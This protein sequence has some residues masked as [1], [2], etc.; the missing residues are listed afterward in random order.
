[1]KY[2]FKGTSANLR[3]NTWVN[4]MDL[5]YGLLLPSGN[6]SAFMLAENIGALFQLFIEGNAKLT[7]LINDMTK[8]EELNNLILSVSTPVTYFVNEMNKYAKELNITNSNWC[9]P[10]GLANK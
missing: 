7:T 3:M 5:F 1:M 2:N 4:I 6:D 8:K 9:N 10:H